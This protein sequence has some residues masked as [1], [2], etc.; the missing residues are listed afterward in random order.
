MAIQTLQGPKARPDTLSLPQT[1]VVEAFLSSS[2]NQETCRFEYR[3]AE[4]NNI[5]FAGGGKRTVVT[6]DLSLAGRL[7]SDSLDLARRATGEAVSS[8]WLTQ[9][10][11]D[12]SGQ[13]YVPK[14]FRLELTGG[15]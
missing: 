14:R 2:E 1:V 9:V 12:G 3:L 10:M 6:T 5:V 4:G 8:F 13:S 11:T 7:V 15:P